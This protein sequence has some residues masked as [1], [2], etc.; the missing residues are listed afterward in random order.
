M[1]KLYVKEGKKDLALLR[2]Y[3]EIAERVKK[4]VL[5]RCDARI[6]VFGSVLSGKVTACSDIDILV[7]C[8]LNREEA[9][10]L[11]VEVIREIGLEVPVQ[12]H[13]VNERELKWYLRFIDE[14]LEV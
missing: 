3:R 13:I 4:L 5:R 14:L 8:N 7:V 1:F 9:L 11:K 10:K 6:Y 2:R 12:L